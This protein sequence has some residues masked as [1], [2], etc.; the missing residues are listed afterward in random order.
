MCIRSFFYPFL[1]AF[2]ILLLPVRIALCALFL[3][4]HT[5]REKEGC[6][7]K[8]LFWI[9]DMDEF[10]LTTPIM[11]IWYGLSPPHDYTYY[12]YMIWMSSTPWLRLLWIYDMDE[13]LP[14]LC[15]LWIYDMDKAS[16]PLTKPIMNI[17]YG[18][19]FTPPD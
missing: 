16:P 12:E 19:S 2:N 4:Y 14:W 15:L 11:N 18:W 3:G 10:P 8:R 5:N 9:Y 1:F 6:V 17:W 13:A 7:K